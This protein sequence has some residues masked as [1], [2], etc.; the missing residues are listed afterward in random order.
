MSG[1]V[2]ENLKGAVRLLLKPLV[3]LLIDQGISFNE[4]AEAAKQAFVE[5]AIREQAEEG[6]LNRSR[7]A[8]VTGLTRKEVTAVMRRA[9]NEERHPKAV[10][11]PAR[12]LHGWFNDPRY[13]APYGMPLDIPYDV[14]EGEQIQPC[15]VDLV[16]SYSGDQSAAQ[17]LEELTRV[18]AV[19][20][21]DAG[22]LHP[23]KRVFLPESISPAMIS[24]FG[25][26]GYN[27]LN[28]LTKNVAK[29]DENS[30]IFDK[31]VFSE[32][33]MSPVEIA[34][35]SDYLKEHGHEFV[36]QADT[37][38]SLITKGKEDLQREE[39][40][41]FRETGLVAVQYINDEELMTNDL[42]QI[43]EVFGVAKSKEE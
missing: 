5:M 6:A 32:V 1:T 39:D 38:L 10:S 16:R 14:P 3:R 41:T 30:G 4:F 15:F 34:R 25:E 20:E 33:K 18:G 27:L 43:L 9:L 17:M 7:V 37:F 36:L 35:F 42:K 24:R 21:T 26:V 40:P 31:R 2:Q 29:P 19:V 12:V 8:I 22:L 23:V 28:T 11:R 13:Q